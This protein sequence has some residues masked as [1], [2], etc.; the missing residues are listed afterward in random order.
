MLS[1]R[2]LFRIKVYTQTERY[3]GVEKIFH[4]NGNKQTKFGVAILIPDKID[5][6]N[7]S[8]ITRDREGPRHST[9]GYYLKKSKTLNQKDMYI[10]MFIA[11]SFK[12]AK[13]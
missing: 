7:N 11:A 1:T 9:F 3:I 4:E 6:L 13:I 8:Y 10:Y 5:F 12:I 2:D